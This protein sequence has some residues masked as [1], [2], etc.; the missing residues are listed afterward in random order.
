MSR[1]GSRPLSILLAVI[2][3]ILIIVGRVN[4][5]ASWGAPVLIVGF[6]LLVVAGLLVYVRRG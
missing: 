3:A 5:D 1:I 2:S 6:A 4:R